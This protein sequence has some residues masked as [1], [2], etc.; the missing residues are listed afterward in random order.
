MPHGWHCHKV[1]MGVIAL[2]FEVLTPVLY[3]KLSLNNERYCSR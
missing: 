1:H 3:G 2:H